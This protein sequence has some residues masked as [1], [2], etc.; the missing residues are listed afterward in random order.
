MPVNRPELLAPAGDW[1]ALKAAVANG[2][3][4]VYFG[5]DQ[6][7]AR[8]RATNFTL[9]ELPEVMAYLHGHNVKG[10]ITFNT[11]I[12]SDELPAAAEYLAAIARARVDAVI[13]QD[14]GIA[15]LVR[16]LCPADATGQS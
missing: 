15:K 16:Q 6:F 14:L 9:A 10:F 2:A 13:V 1:D 12:F 11:L 8:H 7:N 5:L 3:D 4:A